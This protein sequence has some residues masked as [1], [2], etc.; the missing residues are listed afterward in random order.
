MGAVKLCERKTA[1]KSYYVEATGV[2]LYS[3]E[4]LAYYLYENLYLIDD[5]MLGERLCV[6]LENQLG[7][8]ELAQR[9]RNETGAEGRLYHRIMV[10]LK[11]ADYYSEEELK[12]LS[13][14]IKEISGMQ[15]Q[16]RMKYK[17]DEL[18]HNE[19]YWAAVMEYEKILSIRQNSKLP[20]EF[21]AKVWNNLAGCYAR[22]F[23]FDKAAG[24]FET[25][26]EFEKTEE[27]RERACYARKLASYGCEAE[28]TLEAGAS[29]EF[30]QQAG[31]RLK[32][33]EEK[34]K[35]LTKRLVPEK[36]LEMQ[37]KKYHRISCIS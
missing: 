5:E 7:M 20:T 17:A 35:V 32:A 14:K 13:E 26:Y 36:F 28:E 37:E 11:A 34:N 4:E 19:N 3:V 16:E 9:L 23:L 8:G 33:L 24:C 18:M 29:Q 22:L 25:A 31:E 21:Y 12:A 2:H 27:Y 1:R 15:A 10:I 30:L 6:W